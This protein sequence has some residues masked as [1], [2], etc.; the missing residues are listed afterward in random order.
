MASIFVSESSR[1]IAVLEQAQVQLTAMS[2]LPE[3]PD[4]LFAL[5][6]AQES[7]GNTHSAEILRAQV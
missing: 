3:A 2:A 5:A 1:I 4:T 6:V 7:A